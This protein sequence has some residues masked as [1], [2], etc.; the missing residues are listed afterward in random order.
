M[1]AGRREARR[2]EQETMENYDI[3]ALIGTYNRSGLLRGAIERMLAQDTGGLRYELI[4]V[5]NNSTDDT[6]QVVESFIAQG[7]SHVRYLFEG[8]QGVSHARNLGIAN[9][10]APIVAL[11]DDDVRVAA[12]WL[13]SIVRA[14]KA[15]PEADFIGGKVLPEWPHEP[16]AWLTKDHWA[17]LA[18]LDYGDKP[19]RLEHAKSRTLI[20]ANFAA[21]RKVFD[22]VGMFLPRFQRVKDFIG[23]T[24]DH[25]FQLRMYGAGLRGRYCPDIV[26]T[27]AVQEERL[28]KAYHRRWHAGHGMF[29]AMMGIEHEKDDGPCLFNV[30]AHLYRRF[31]WFARQWVIACAKRD[32][33]LAL[34][35]ENE[36]RYMAN[37]MRTLAAQAPGNARRPAVLE[38]GLF[39]GAVVRRKLSAVRQATLPRRLR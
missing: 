23:S 30:P 10:R 20:T 11:T 29:S 15:H 32:P 5:D 17:P 18:I 1:V 19:L 25:E 36:M 14:F 8:R 35:Y 22:E 28:L 38:V 33:A 2:L 27:A 9:A 7:H 6:R 24:E 26:A 21:R 13:S 12:D 3:T 34:K 31:A 16:P 39:L 37:Y 4:I